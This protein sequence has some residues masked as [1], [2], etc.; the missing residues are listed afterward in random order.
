MGLF[1]YLPKIKDIL[2][3][4]ST[5]IIGVILG[6]MGMMA[7]HYLSMV[8]YPLPEGVTMEDAEA[9]NKY[10]AIA[11]LGAMLLV[12]ISHAMGSFIG[13]VVATL[14]SQISKWKNSTAFKYQWLVIGLIFTY[15]GWMNLQELTHPDW[16]K[17]DLLFYL[18]AAYLGYKLVA[19]RN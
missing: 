8:F 15:A 19:K 4:I 7:M 2:R 14:L 17:I 18:P 3:A 5:T 13:A 6:M 16:F 1:L 12:I 11:P 10:M 9:L